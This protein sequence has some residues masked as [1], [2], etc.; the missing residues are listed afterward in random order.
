MKFKQASTTKFVPDPFV[1]QQL[2]PVT[3]ESD[4]WQPV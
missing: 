4:H 2:S 3:R 1:N